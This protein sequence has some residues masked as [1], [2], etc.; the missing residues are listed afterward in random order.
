MK[1]FIRFSKGKQ[2][3]LKAKDI[4][5]YKKNNQIDTRL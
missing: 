3:N 4:I 2:A 1:Y 5:M